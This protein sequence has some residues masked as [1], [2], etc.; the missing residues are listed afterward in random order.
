M[1]L[2]VE[3]PFHVYILAY[4]ALSERAWYPGTS[5]HTTVVMC[6]ESAYQT[7]IKPST[8]TQADAMMKQYENG[9]CDWSQVHIKPEWR[10]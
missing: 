3:T 6:K 7:G 2:Y 10:E 4:N 9:L 1:Y 5:Y 8:L